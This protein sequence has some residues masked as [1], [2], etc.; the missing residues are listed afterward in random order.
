[1]LI[2]LLFVSVSDIECLQLLLGRLGGGWNLSCSLCNH[3]D[4]LILNSS[5]AYPLRGTLGKY[6][7]DMLLYRYLHAT[8]PGRACR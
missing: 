3:Q 4:A 1:M 2:Y 8:C 7:L 6:H 5:Q